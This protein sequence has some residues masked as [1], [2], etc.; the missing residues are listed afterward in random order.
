[1]ERGIEIVTGHALTGFDGQS[2]TLTCEYTGAT[3]QIA[4][5]GAVMVTQRAQRDALYHDI[6][7]KVGGD[8]SA[9]PF[10]LRRIGD[11]EA[12]GIIAAAVY[13]GHRYA[14]ELEAVVDIDEPMQHDRPVVGSVLPAAPE[15]V[16]AGGDPAYLPTLLQ[17]YEEEVEGEAW[18]AALAAAMPLPRQRE[19]LLLLADVERRTAEAVRP[20]IDRYG[21]TPKPQAILAASGRAQAASAPQNWDGLIAR[22]RK[23]F[24]AYMPQF[25]ALE[26]MAPPADRPVLAR[27]TAHERAAIDFLEREAKGDPDCTAPLL[28]LVFAEAAAEAA[29][30]GGQDR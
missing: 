3:R 30:Q 14:S 2:A 28:D 5:R 19:K 11:C 17:Y 16:A 15:P 22:M 26:R 4:A 18:F 7:G 20:L 24:P 6:M 25:E 27:M 8:A 29:R 9:L 10:T 13:A 1:M 23:T 21:L 12:P